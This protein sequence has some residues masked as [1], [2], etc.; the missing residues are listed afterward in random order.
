[1]ELAFH[2]APSE[3]F[4]I[5]FYM[6]GHFAA[7]GWYWRGYLLQDMSYLLAMDITVR[8]LLL[9]NFGLLMSG[10]PCVTCVPWRRPWDDDGL[11]W[12]EHTMEHPTPELVHKGRESPYRDG[13]E[14][15]WTCT[16]V[17]C[18]EGRKSWEKPEKLLK[19]DDTEVG[20]LCNKSVIPTVSISS[21]HNRPFSILFEI[22]PSNSFR[23]DL[24][25]IGNQTSDTQCFSF[26]FNLISPNPLLNW[27]P[28]PRP[29][30]LFYRWNR[31]LSDSTTPTC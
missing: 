22:V 7:L 1:M 23:G 11:R 10:S 28:G 14:L 24:L 21:G 16:V 30:S 26:S 12:F 6:T 5:A 15:D 25:L 8:L 4:P 13:V 27:Q 29:A 20:L 18:S 9:D 3:V 19:R 31:H 2:L 17:A